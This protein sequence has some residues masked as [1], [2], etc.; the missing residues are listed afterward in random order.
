MVTA[1]SRRRTHVYIVTGSFSATSGGRTRSSFL[2]ASALAGSYG[3]CSIL[4][5]NWRLD[6]DESA[7][8]WL[9]SVGAP[10]N[11]Q[12]ENFYEYL[13]AEPLFGGDGP[14]TPFVAPDGASYNAR[15][16]SWD[17]RASD[18]SLVRRH[19]LREDGG[20]NYVDEWSSGVRIRHL[21]ADRNGATRVVSVV[22][23]GTREYQSR[24]RRTVHGR[25]FAEER[26]D[27]DGDVTMRVIGG[28][29][30][31]EGAYVSVRDL[32]YGWIRYLHDRADEAVFLSE[33]RAYDGHVAVLNPHLPP[34]G[35]RTVA[36]VHSNHLRPPYADV[37]SVWT[38]NDWA[39]SHASDFGALVVL[40]ERQRRDVEAHYGPCPSLVTIGHPVAPSPRPRLRT[41]IHA[42]LSRPPRIVVVTR[43]VRVK[44]LDDVL[45]AFRQVRRAVRGARLEVWGSGDEEEALQ[46]RAEKLKLKGVRFAGRTDDPVGAFRRGQVSVSTSITEGFG[47]STL[48][49]LSAGTPVVAYDYRYGPRDLVVPGRNGYLVP[50]GDVDELARRIV[51][52]LSRPRRARLMGVWA[53][54]ARVT[55]SQR[56]WV[57]RWVRVIDSTARRQGV[58]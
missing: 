22:R 39:L 51:D 29:A 40:T 8:G 47:M 30:D 54:T 26:I 5:F 35:L 10:A 58:D 14:W 43:L 37:H 48:E 45:E 27:G 53:S 4:T 15:K 12:V 34:G 20:L 31:T 44:R 56:R 24:E 23:P 17:E 18:G 19:V 32:E 11:V 55:R 1:A 16:S 49:S 2:K 41:S 6:Y 9:R 50:D 21:N 52:V 3:S 33:A 46:A 38:Y 42:V 57:R 7:R 25:V 36:T 28:P 13:A